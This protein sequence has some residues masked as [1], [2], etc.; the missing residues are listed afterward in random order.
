MILGG[1]ANLAG[2]RGGDVSKIQAFSP[3]GSTRR[4]AGQRASDTIHDVLLYL[5]QSSSLST[6]DRVYYCALHRNEQGA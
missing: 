6:G 1:D 2:K 5:Y 4:K 3:A